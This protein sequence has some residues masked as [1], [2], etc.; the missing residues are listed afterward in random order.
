MEAAQA[1]AAE[2]AAMRAQ[3]QA[4]QEAASKA[5]AELHADRAKLEALE[6]EAVFARQGLSDLEAALQQE[7]VQHEESTC[8]VT[9]TRTL[10]ELLGDLCSTDYHSP[11]L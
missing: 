8:K 7:R 6:E 4:L 5:Q 9:F 2:L 1:H 3:L 10:A 11:P